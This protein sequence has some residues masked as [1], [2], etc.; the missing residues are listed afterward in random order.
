MSDNILDALDN[1]HYRN[2]VK[3]ILNLDID[4]IPNIPKVCAGCSIS[5]ICSVLPTLLSIIRLGITLEVG[6]CQFQKSIKITK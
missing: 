5:V 6:S 3:D 1:N 4:Q 2:D